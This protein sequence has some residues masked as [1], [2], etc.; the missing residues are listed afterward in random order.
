[1]VLSSAKTL[2]GLAVG[3]FR[4]VQNEA[5]LSQSFF[6]FRHFLAV[7]QVFWRMLRV[8]LQTSVR[9]PNNSLKAVEFCFIS[10]RD[11]MGV[12][13]KSEPS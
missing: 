5:N 10:S 11:I 3:S 1:M 8:P 4:S 6:E 12:E 7:S 13:I 9:R 2:G